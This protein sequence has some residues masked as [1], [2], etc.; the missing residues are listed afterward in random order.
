MWPPPRLPSLQIATIGQTVSP[1]ADDDVLSLAVDRG[2][3]VTLT[4]LGPVVS[5]GAAV[6]ISAVPTD[7]RWVN[8]AVLAGVG[9]SLVGSAR[10]SRTVGRPVWVV[11]GSSSE[12]SGLD[13]GQQDGRRVVRLV[14]E[15]V[16]TGNGA[17]EHGGH[18]EVA[19]QQHAERLGPIG[20]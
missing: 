13:Q 19:P 3:N 20:P 8:C 17:A 2:A 9:K 7:R 1:Q 4:L 10:R 15:L 14:A 11:T 18:E 12:E 6:S 5:S 16:D